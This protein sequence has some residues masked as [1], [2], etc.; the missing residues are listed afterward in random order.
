MA[1]H[2][3]ANGREI[4][5]Q[6]NNWNI[7]IGKDFNLMMF[8][9][10]FCFFFFSFYFFFW[11]KK[12]KCERNYRELNSMSCFKLNQIQC[13]KDNRLCGCERTFTLKFLRFSAKTAHNT[14]QTRKN[15]RFCHRILF[16]A[17]ATSDESERGIMIFD[18][19]YHIISLS[20]ETLFFFYRCH[21]LFDVWLD[22]QEWPDIESI[23]CDCIHL[24][25]LLFL[26]TSR[27]SYFRDQ[28]WY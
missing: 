12:M 26:L 3:H 22:A 27:H 10:L 18:L 4:D 15:S 19:M 20:V 1:K 17:D 7:F 13:K 23:R 14:I 21:C 5:R 11:W 9:S 16:V 25:S 28:G 24:F 8:F 6:S 2:R